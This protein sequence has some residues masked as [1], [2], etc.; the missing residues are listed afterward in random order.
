M[1]RNWVGISGTNSIPF[2]G[3]RPKEGKD[4]LLDA[5]IVERNQVCIYVS[6]LSTSC[7][8]HYY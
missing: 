3:I 4:K 6:F 2:F 5:V 1:I 7:F 8:R